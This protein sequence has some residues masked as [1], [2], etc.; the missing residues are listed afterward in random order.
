MQ[1][2][3]TVASLFSK[4]PISSEK[5]KIKF[6]FDNQTENEDRELTEAEKAQITMQSKSRWG[7]ISGLFAWNKR[8]QSQPPEMKIPK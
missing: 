4:T 2:T 7:L 6:T 8:K 5:F 1:L 3:A